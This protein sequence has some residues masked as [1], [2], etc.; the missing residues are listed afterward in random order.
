MG[1]RVCRRVRLPPGKLGEL[2]VSLISKPRVSAVEIRYVTP[3]RLL[4]DSLLVKLPEPAKRLIARTLALA[5]FNRV[6]LF[7]EVCAEK[8]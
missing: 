1:L 5:G 6:L 4:H 7:C 3:L 2:L 8:W